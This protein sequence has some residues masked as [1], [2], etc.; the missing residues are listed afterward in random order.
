MANEEH[1]KILKFGADAWNVWRKENPNVQPDL[2][3]AD[4]GPY[5]QGGGI[6]TSPLASAPISGGTIVPRNLSGYDLSM[7]DLR[8]ADL[9][10]A[11]LSRANLRGALLGPPLVTG[12]P[13]GGFTLGSDALG[14]ATPTNLSEANFEEADLKGAVLRGVE[15]GEANFHGANLRRA[16][17][18]N[19]NLAQA[20]LTYARLNGAELTNAEIIKANFT[21]AIVDK[22]TIGL[23]ILSASQIGQL[24]REEEDLSHQ[25]FSLK[26]MRHIEILNQGAEVWNE[27]RERNPETIPDLRGASLGNRDL[28]R[29]NLIDANLSD[30]ILSSADLTEAD[31]GRTNLHGALINGTTFLGVSNLIQSQLDHA[32][33][34]PKNPPTDLPEGLMLPRLRSGD[35]DDPPLHKAVNEGH[36]WRDDSPGRPTVVVRIQGLSDEINAMA[37]AMVAA[38]ALLDIDPPHFESNSQAR[39]FGDIRNLIAE[40]LILAQTQQDEIAEMK[41]SSLVD[42]ERIAKLE[43]GLAAARTEKEPVLIEAARKFFSVAAPGAGIA[44]AA[45]AAAAVGMTTIVVARELG[46]DPS[47]LIEVWS[48]LKPTG[49]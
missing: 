16:D 15:A 44:A 34:D 12:Q 33:Y 40:L 27:W 8:G 45:G 11:N 32:S 18:K 48:A 26:D 23:E 2:R 13:L 10:K 36:D 46:I 22:S 43:A 31:L 39:A 49:K 28:A 19:A 25:N 17:L 30:S 6:S 35:P 7:A 47:Q 41:A 42:E 21:G 4:L 5:E 20:V 37:N 14:G 9:R 24:V 38:K 1:L 29:L 3:G